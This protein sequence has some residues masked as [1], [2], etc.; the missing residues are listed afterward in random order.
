MKYHSI[1]R[2][3]TDNEQIII[4]INYWNDK[5]SLD[6]Q[7]IVVGSSVFELRKGGFSW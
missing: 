2:S 6:V 5:R 7:F 3:S 1:Q 4:R